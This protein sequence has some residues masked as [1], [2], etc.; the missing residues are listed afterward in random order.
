VSTSRQTKA[1]GAD[2]KLRLA[3]RDG[4]IDPAYTRK[5]FVHA[6]PSTLRKKVEADRELWLQLGVEELFTE[7]E[8]KDIPLEE[9]RRFA[10]KSLDAALKMCEESEKTMNG[11]GHLRNLFTESYSLRDGAASQLDGIRSEEALV[12]ARIEKLGERIQALKKLGRDGAATAKKAAER[13]R[14]LREQKAKL[15]DT[16]NALYRDDASWRPWRVGANERTYE[17]VQ[18]GADILVR[19]GGVDG[20]ESQRPIFRWPH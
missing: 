17:T 12:D 14:E 1:V 3:L 18:Q 7:A 6:A 16:Q 15:I 5:E 19:A 4:K 9:R 11:G 8:R 13:M 20:A 10:S 2:V